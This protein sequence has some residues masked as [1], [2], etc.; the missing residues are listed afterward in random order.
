MM[1]DPTTL[2]LYNKATNSPT[3]LADLPPSALYSELSHAPVS[4][5]SLTILSRAALVV[6]S[7]FRG[8]QAREWAD[9]QAQ[10]LFPLRQKLSKAWKAGGSRDRAIFLQQKSTQLQEAKVRLSIAQ[11][12]WEDRKLSMLEAAEVKFANDPDSLARFSSRLASA[13]S[14]SNE[15]ADSREETIQTYVSRIAAIRESEVSLGAEL[16]RVNRTYDAKHHKKVVRG[17]YEKR[18]SSEIGSELEAGAALAFRLSKVVN[19]KRQDLVLQKIQRKLD[20]EAIMLHKNMRFVAACVIQEFVKGRVREKYPHLKEVLEAKQEK[21]RASARDALRRNESRRQTG[22]RRL[23][24]GRSIMNLFGAIAIISRMQRDWREYLGITHSERKI[25]SAYALLK[26]MRED[27]IAGQEFFR[28]AKAAHVAEIELAVDFNL[29]IRRK[30]FERS[31]GGWSEYARDR[32]RRKAWIHNRMRHRKAV[33]IEQWFTL[34]MMEKR[35]MI[36]RIMPNLFPPLLA[37]LVRFSKSNDWRQFLLEL[38]SLFGEFDEE[39]QVRSLEF[40]EHTTNKV[41]GFKN[42]SKLNEM[43]TYHIAN[44]GLRKTVACAVVGKEESLSFAFWRFAHQCSIYLWTKANETAAS[45]ELVT[46]QEEIGLLQNMLHHFL[47]TKNL[48]PPSFSTKFRMR[49]KLFLR[50]H[51]N[52]E[53]CKNCL[54]ILPLLKSHCDNCDSVQMPRYMRET[55][56]TT[57]TDL[58]ADGLLGNSSKGTAYIKAL[59]RGGEKDGNKNVVKTVRDLDEPVDLFIYHCALCVLAPYGGWRRAQLDARECWLGAVRGAARIVHGMKRRGIFSI[60]DL[61]IV[62]EE[63][64]ERGGGK[65]G[66]KGKEGGNFR[67]LF[68]RGGDEANFCEKVRD[69]LKLLDDVLFDALGESGVNDADEGGAGG[70]GGESVSGG[71]Q[72]SWRRLASINNGNTNKKVLNKSVWGRG[73]DGGDFKKTVEFGQSW[74]RPQ[75]SGSSS[76]RENKKSRKSGGGRGGVGLKRGGTVVVRVPVGLRPLTR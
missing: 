54:A 30:Y 12:D 40:E 23:A 18:R 45:N 27:R 14:L 43:L 39:S 37:E 4:P 66:G 29:K 50:W 22:V 61:W 26:R 16:A 42:F 11:R 1:A 63:E 49:S 13:L 58:P 53:L 15:Q 9:N 31:F 3:R 19:C 7:L 2:N 25:S 57:H 21:V 24:K 51:G 33:L 70:G 38:S 74:A 6:Q 34:V 36:N 48:N 44:S 76:G 73:L 69:L 68:L 46:R 72:K 17:K 28:R 59:R 56:A 47:M 55:Q 64:E 32:S 67:E 41:I 5:R 71:S 65:G 10:R 60:A 62:F 75:S 35:E 20:E 52:Q 8:R